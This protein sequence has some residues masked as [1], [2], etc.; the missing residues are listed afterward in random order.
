MRHWFRRL[1]F[2]KLEAKAEELRPH[3]AWVRPMLDPDYGFTAEYARLRPRPAEFAPAVAAELQEIE[4]RLVEFEA[5]PDDA[6]TED[7]IDKAAACEA[8]HDELI[9]TSE[10][11]AVYAPEDR[12]APA[13]S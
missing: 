9:E 5:L 3:W 1:A 2:A 6:W 11:E 13:S 4:D 7:L 12:A 8:R 10:A